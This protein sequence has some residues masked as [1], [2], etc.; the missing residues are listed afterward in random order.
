VGRPRE[1][2][3]E[4]AVSAARDLFWK[5]GFAGATLS[6]LERAMRLSRSSLYQA[7]G[8]KE[9]LFVGALAS[10]VDGFV[11]RLL[12]PME[13]PNATEQ[14]VIDFFR[15]L[16]S[17]FR[18]DRL[19]NHG[20][21]WVNS[22]VEFSGQP[23]R[24][25]LARASEYRKR[26]MAAFTNALDSGSSFRDQQQLNNIARRLTLSTFGVWIQAR[27]DPIEAARSCDALVTWLKNAD[28]AS[29]R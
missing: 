24:K 28:Y 18:H 1:F 21:L 6:D 27:F 5:Q 9:E 14:D 7:F 15:A 25:E 12:G 11:N 8:T 23:K 10:Y 29:L 17:R 26:L 2:N 3:V 13:A 4:D 20:C 22:I 19:A 16:G